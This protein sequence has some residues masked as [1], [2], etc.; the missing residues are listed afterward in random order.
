MM[1]DYGLEASEGFLWKAM[2]SFPLA[3]KAAEAEHSGGAGSLE[4]GGD[5]V[6]SQCPVPS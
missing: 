5:Q 4:V 6:T 2:N 3:Q 1:A